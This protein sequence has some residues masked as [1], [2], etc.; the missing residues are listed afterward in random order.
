MR[1]AWLNLRFTVPERRAIFTV[2]LERLGFEVRHEL[3]HDPREGDVLVTWNR[4]HDGDEAA[5]IF[6]ARNLP[7]IVTENATWGNEFAGRN[8]YT[9]T[10]NF[11]N[12]SGTFP[13]DGA[14]RFDSL[15]VGLGDWRRDGETVV[16]ASRGIGPA[17]YRMPPNWPGQQRGRVRAHP[18]RFPERAKPLREDLANCGQVVTWG[19]GA[20]TTALMW[21]IPVESHQ[22]QWIAAQDNT[23]AGRLAMFRRLAWAQWTMDEIASGEPFARLLNFTAR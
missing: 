5:R 18:G 23:D 12:V 22:P 3:T 16:L 13:V 11:H 14:E 15:G 9:L 19:S 1:R 8:W 20:A 17:A 10:R 2:G 6:Q 21:G 7:V 4:I